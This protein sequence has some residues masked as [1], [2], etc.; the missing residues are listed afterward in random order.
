MIAQNNAVASKHCAV[1]CCVFL[2]RHSVL[3]DRQ[4][5]HS[6][7]PLQFC[8]GRLKSVL[9]T[10]PSA[11]DIQAST[12]QCGSDR[13]SIGGLLYGCQHC[14]VCPAQTEALPCKGASDVEYISDPALLCRSGLSRAA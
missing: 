10:A 2:S 6:S 1:L 9:I 11:S 4:V 13:S 14:I 12:L 8:L 3:R 7:A 5:Q